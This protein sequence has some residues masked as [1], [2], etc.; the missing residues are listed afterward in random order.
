MTPY[1]TLKHQA[2]VSSGK[3]P[4]TLS[5]IEKNAILAAL[6]KYGSNK[7]EAARAL[8][9]GLTTLYRKLEQYGAEG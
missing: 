1:L 6:V 7:A 8:G 5:D 4:E 9:I 3:H 2:G